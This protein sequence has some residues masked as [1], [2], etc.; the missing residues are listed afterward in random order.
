MLP[1]KAYGNLYAVASLYEHGLI[2][3]TVA[4]EIPDRDDRIE[5]LLKCPGRNVLRNRWNVPV[6][7]FG[8]DRRTARR[9]NWD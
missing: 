9:T 4:I 5:M 8:V 2:G 1:G 3:F 6:P 7:Q